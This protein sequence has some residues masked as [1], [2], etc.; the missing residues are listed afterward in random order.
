MSRRVF[1]GSFDECVLNAISSHG[2]GTILKDMFEAQFPDPRDRPPY[3]PARFQF[4]VD[5]TTSTR[6][7]YYIMPEPIPKEIVPKPLGM[8]NEQLQGL[9]DEALDWLAKDVINEMDRRE[10]LAKS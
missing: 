10:R 6:D 1:L 8:T 9:T 4:D 5:V 7:I 3:N 2:V